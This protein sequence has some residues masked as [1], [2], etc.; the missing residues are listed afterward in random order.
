MGRYAMNVTQ[1][2]QNQPVQN[3]DSV[4]RNWYSFFINVRNYINW[5]SQSGTTANR[6]TQFLMVGQQYYDTTLGYPVFV[7]SV[8]PVVWHN[9]AGAAV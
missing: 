4:D 8:S 1:P 6:P 9:A 3:G 7:H 5:N 2:T